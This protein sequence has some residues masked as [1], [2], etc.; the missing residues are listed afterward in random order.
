VRDADAPPHPEPV[1]ESVAVERSV[2]RRRRHVVAVTKSVAGAEPVAESYALTGGDAVAGGDGARAGLQRADRNAAV[3]PAGDTIAESDTLTQSDGGAESG[4]GA[5]FVARGSFVAVTGRDGGAERGTECEPHGAGLSSQIT[6]RRWD[7][8]PRPLAYKASAL[9]LSYIGAPRVFRTQRT[10]AL[11]RVTE[12]FVAL[13][14]ADGSE[15]KRG[16]REGVHRTSAA[17]SRRARC[18]RKHLDEVNS[19]DGGSALT[20]RDTERGEPQPGEHERGNG[21]ILQIFTI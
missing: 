6:S 13:R 14:S 10:E 12:G 8:N 17:R 15:V 5:E 18:A 7:L 1:A 16:S 4:A 21:R 11:G 19:R 9:P 2:T 20:G 3:H